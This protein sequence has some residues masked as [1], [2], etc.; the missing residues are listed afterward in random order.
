MSPFDAQPFP[1]PQCVQ[2]LWAGLPGLYKHA[3]LFAGHPSGEI[4]ADD[5]MPLVGLGL[6]PFRGLAVRLLNAVVDGHDA[7]VPIS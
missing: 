3:K 4:P 7:E 2:L 6:I 5:A 1:N